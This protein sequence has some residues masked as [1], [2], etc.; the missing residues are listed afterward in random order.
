M[1][2][3]CSFEISKKLKKKKKQAYSPL[4]SSSQI[5]KKTMRSYFA[6]QGPA[7]ERFI[8]LSFVAGTEGQDFHVWDSK[9]EEGEEERGRWGKGGAPKE[10][11]SQM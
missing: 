2:D 1:R 8:V 10:H 6:W 7:V 3:I 9:K 5:S 4:A 11:T